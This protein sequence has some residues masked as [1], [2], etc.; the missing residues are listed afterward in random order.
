[1]RSDL[2][3]RGIGGAL[4]RMLIDY[5]AADGLAPAR[6]HGARART[7]RCSASSRGLGFTPASDP[8]DPALVLTTLDLG[9]RARLAEP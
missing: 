3:G 9:R 1:M 4:M 8:D 2:K 5:A 7:G 6:G